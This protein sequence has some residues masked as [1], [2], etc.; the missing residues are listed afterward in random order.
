VDEIHKVESVTQ[1]IKENSAIY[2]KAMP[3]FIQAGRHLSDLGDMVAAL[4]N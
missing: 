4:K 2:R 3:V 1:P